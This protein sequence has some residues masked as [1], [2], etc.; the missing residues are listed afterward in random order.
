[1]ELRQLEYFVAVAEEANFTRA[2]ARVHVA[3]PGVSAQIKRLERELGHELFERAGGV[4]LTEVGVAVLP[5]ARS[6]LAA[7]A[8][9]RQVADEYSGLVRGHVSIGTIL[10]N[11][12][13]P[14]DLPAVLAAFNERH[15]SVTTTLIEANSDLLV[16]AL[17]DG[18]VDVALVGRST[19]PPP[20]LATQVIVDDALVAAVSFDDPLAS[21]PGI[22]LASLR[23]RALVC[24]PR[25]TG[26]RTCL[27]TACAGAGFRPRVAFEAS[28]PDVVARLAA[29]GLGVA[30][31][32][33]RSARAR[34]REVHALTITRPRM[35]ARI[36]LAWRSRGP[37]TPAG[38]ALIEHIREWIATHST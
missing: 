5:Y 20:E 7:V 38:R 33:E 14:V 1:M 34:A 28:D 24:L 29:R 23:D 19:P 32:P 21:R 18:E 9:A 6:A 16:Q 17:L 11:A 12:S 8:G 13:P 25:G 4:R 27:D 15:P 2:A 3:Q 35:R 36:E 30:V 10:V 26:V 37:L 31:L 22:T